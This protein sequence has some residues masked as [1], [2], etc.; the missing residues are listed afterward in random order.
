LSSGEPAISLR[1]V[2][3]ADRDT[4]LCWRNDP[5]IVAKGSSHREVQAEEHRMWFEETIRAERR[6]MFIVL[7]QD[8][9]I[10][11]VRFDR[12]RE[13]DCVIS[14]YLLRHF[15]GKGWGVEAIRVG[16][17]LIFQAWDV[18][19]VIACVR[20]DNPTGLSAFCKAGFQQTDAA[21]ACPPK[22]SSLAF[23][24]KSGAA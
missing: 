18:E 8:N 23:L 11:Q 6:K 4:I 7:N 19:R 9:P 24:R 16:C 22:H 10:G 12:E 2:T 5:Y 20:L 3:A 21:Q 14:V 1:P 17:N 13:T 15:T